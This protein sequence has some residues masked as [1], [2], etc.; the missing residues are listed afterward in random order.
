MFDCRLAC[1]I[2]GW[3]GGTIHQVS[4]ET[5]VSVSRLLDLEDCSEPALRTLF[6]RP[7]FEHD[8]SDCTFLGHE[9]NHDLYF[10]ASEPTIIARFSDEGSE[11]S[12]GLVFGLSEDHILNKT[13]RAALSLK[14]PREKIVDYFDK[15]HQSFPERL[16]LFHK[17]Y[18]EVTGQ[19]YSHRYFII[20]HKDLSK[21]VTYE[22]CEIISL[23]DEERAQY[24]K[25]YYGCQAIIIPLNVVRR[26][27]NME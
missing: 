27:L 25:D 3:Q 7:K 1:N 26:H 16:S 18:E 15:Y 9:N 20:H 12:S 21:P 2:L 24:V 13:L 11:Y 17:I 10:C 8:C 14:E 5:G 23:T 6:K 22:E 4:K 19:P